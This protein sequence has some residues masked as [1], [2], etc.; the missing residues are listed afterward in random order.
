MDQ[1]SIALTVIGAGLL[2]SASPGPSMAYVLSRSVQFGSSGGLASSLGLAV[3]GM[4][5]ALF[6]ALGLSLIAMQFPWLL[7]LIKYVGAAYLAYLAYDS[8]CAA[9]ATV[10]NSASA[11]NPISDA[12]AIVQTREEFSRQTFWRL[13]SNGVLIELSNPKTIIF[14]LSFMPQFVSQHSTIGMFLLS[15]L[16]PITAIP[17]D[18]LAIFAGGVIANRVRSHYWLVRAVNI[19]VALVLAGIALMVLFLD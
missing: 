1:L 11:D 5:H 6:A 7:Q 17:A 16:I 2:L 19:A 10:D 8:L 13:F 4:M 18:L 3:G 14:F 15:S 9:F 12:D